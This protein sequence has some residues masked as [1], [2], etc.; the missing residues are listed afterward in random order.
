MPVVG[1]TGGSAAIT[2]RS[3]TSARAGIIRVVAC[4]REL[5]TCASKSLSWAL[6]FAYA[7]PPASEILGQAV[8]YIILTVHCDI[9]HLMRGDWSRQNLRTP[10]G[11]E[12]RWV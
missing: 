4:L 11:G 8:T 12:N 3:V 10:D 6:K 5:A 9:H 7:T 2:S 1:A